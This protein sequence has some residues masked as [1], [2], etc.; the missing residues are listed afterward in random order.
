MKK[1]LSGLL[2]LVMTGT[3]TVS[4]FAATGDITAE[5]VTI[6]DETITNDDTLNYILKTDVSDEEGMLR[7]SPS[8]LLKIKLKLEGEADGDMTFFASQKLG[9][10]ENI[11]AD[12]IQFID[13]KTPDANGMISIQFRP[14][15]TD[16]AGIYNMQAKS[17]GASVFSRFYKTVADQIQPTLTDV[18]DISTPKKQ[19]IEITVNGYTEAWK[20]A[21]TLY[22]VKNG[23][24]A[25]IPA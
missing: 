15:T 3:L 2:A 23:E 19:D 25:E 24:Q 16:T 4:A 5:E 6:N 12:K 21:N 14:R 22:E 7:I 20:E 18:S 8:T 10:G 11:T 9:E 17:K 13:Q 1:V